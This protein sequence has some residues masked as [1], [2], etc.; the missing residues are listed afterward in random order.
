LCV[1]AIENMCF[2]STIG[3]NKNHISGEIIAA[4]IN[5]SS[6]FFE[7]MKQHGVQ[8]HFMGGETADVGDLVRTIIIDGTITCRMKRSDVID[9]AQI[10]AGNVIV[11]FASFGQT[12]YETEYNSGIGSNG[13]TSARHDVLGKFYENAFPESYDPMVAESV[14]FT[15]NCRLTDMET[16]TK[17]SVGKLLLSPT[18]TYLPVVKKIFE[19]VG[20]KNIHGMVHCSGGGQTKVLH[21]V[22]N[23]HIIKNNL[24]DVPPVFKLIQQQSQT[25]WKEMYQ[26]FNMGHRLEMYVD[27]SL[28]Q[29]LIDIAASFN[30][31]A[32]IIGKVETANEKTVTLQSQHGTF[33][34]H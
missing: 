6:T 26:V 33:I 34:Y 7:T 14:R 31:P 4:I 22:D 28:A 1:G 2:T 8:I 30:L 11:G 18:R 16:E 3:R 25:D 23:L 5:G 12:N 13:I 29:Q 24:F 27:E 9:N 32:Q 20:R 21:F 19:T 15:G 10:K 17:L